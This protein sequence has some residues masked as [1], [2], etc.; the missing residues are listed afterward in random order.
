MNVVGGTAD[1]KAAYLQTLK[2]ALKAS[3]P[4]AFPKALLKKILGYS[5]NSFTRQVAISVLHG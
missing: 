5:E 3:G 2:N 4:D 1:E